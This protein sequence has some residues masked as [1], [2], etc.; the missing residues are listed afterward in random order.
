MTKKTERYTHNIYFIGFSGNTKDNIRVD[1][2][3]VIN[4]VS[5]DY[6][7]VGQKKWLNIAN[8]E[9]INESFTIIC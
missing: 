4:K 5:Y 3:F 7:D 8:E 1:V 2:R 9:H 6:T